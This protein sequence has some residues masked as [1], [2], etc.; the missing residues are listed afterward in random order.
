MAQPGILST[1]LPPGED[2]VPRALADIRRDMRELGPSIMHSFQ[3]V[4]DELAA[5]QAT[6]DTT[7]ANLAANV[8]VT[9]T[10]VADIAANV[11]SINAIIGNE[12]LPLA[13]H[14]DSVNFP[15][16]VAWATRATVTVTVPAGYTRALVFA[17]GQASVVN[18]TGGLDQLCLDT[19]I[20]GVVP[21]GWLATTDVPSTNIGSV[22]AAGTK[23]LTGLT[24]GGTFTVAARV[25]TAIAAWGANVANACNVDASVTFLR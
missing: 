5:H 3:S 17:V 7:V 13:P 6:L 14:G 2:W 21:P 24:G 11:A 23:L 10:N 8:A 1:Q 22:A 20:N 15:M 9:N 12:V 16:T 18:T 25:S 19:L 4:V